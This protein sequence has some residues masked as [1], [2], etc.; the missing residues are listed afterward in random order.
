MVLSVSAP[1]RQKN[2]ISEAT[3]E[4]KLAKAL[5]ARGLYSW[6]TSDQFKP[7]VPDRYVV[8]GNWI[9]I[10]AIPYTGKR[11][12]TPVRFFAPCQKNELDRLHERGDRAW[13][14]ILFQPEQGEATVLLCPW[15][16][17]RDKGQMTRT[18]IEDASIACGS[19]AAL[20]YVVD[21]RFNTNDDRYSNYHTEG[22]HPC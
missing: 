5:K 21:T 9:E 20:Q 4:G 1:R 19:A 2:R 11:A 14:C 12:I 17:L 10:K 18:E 22:F 8:G 3:F 15:I 6:H 13:A 16:V 7:G